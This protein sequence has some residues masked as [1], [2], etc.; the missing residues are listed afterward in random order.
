MPFISYGSED[1]TPYRNLIAV[2]SS[3]V[4]ANKIVAYGDALAVAGNAGDVW[5]YRSNGLRKR[6]NPTFAGTIFAAVGIGT[7]LVVHSQNNGVW[8]TDDYGEN[9]A[10]SV[11]AL[12]ALVVG[13]A[14]NGSR[15]VLSSSTG[16]QAYYSDDAGE[17]WT[18]GGATL[19][20][21]VISAQSIT[22]H[23]QLGKFIMLANLTN[24]YYE[25]S[26]GDTWNEVI[27]T[28]TVAGS[29]FRAQVFS[30]I[31]NTLIFGDGT[32]RLYTVNDAAEATLLRDNCFYNDVAGLSTSVYP[33][34]S[35]IE[36]QNAVYSFHDT[37]GV[38]FSTG[39]LVF[40]PITAASNSSI[41]N[42]DDTAIFNSELW[43][44][45]GT[46]MVK[47]LTQ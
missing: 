40:K 12:P 11:T 23:P 31:Y 25:S 10:Q 36:F 6:F 14:S 41:L 38:Q 37:G 33:C 45:G 16:N 1:K 3:G 28:G 35:L 19:V 27:V 2:D 30:E 21:A 17:T 7:R 46:A 26:D 5:V 4:T 29:T 18:L 42:I 34:N 9:W 39:D 15:L 20:G 8:Y 44:V 24:R 43:G 32:G 13:M 22:Y 47:T